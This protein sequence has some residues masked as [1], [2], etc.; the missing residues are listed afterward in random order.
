MNG[1][2]I[3]QFL[4]AHGIIPESIEHNG[5][6]R[7]KLTFDINSPHSEIIKS[8]NG[9]LWSKT[10]KAWHIP[11][12]KALLEEMVQLINE[13]KTADE[14]DTAYLTTI[15]P[16]S[17]LENYAGVDTIKIIPDTPGQ[18]DE[19]KNYIKVHC[20]RFKDFLQAQRY[21]ENTIRSYTEGLKIFLVKMLPLQV[22]EITD[23]DTIHFFKSYTY[24]KNLSIGWQRL[25]INAVKLFYKT[26]EHKKFNIENLVRPHK[27]KLLP[28]VLSKT[29]VENILKATKNEKH[30]VMLAL[31]YSCG[32]RR[33]EVLRL[34]PSNIDSDRKMLF[35]K[36]AKGRKDR[37]VPLPEKIIE[38]LRAYYKNYRPKKLLFEGQQEGKP[39]SERSFNLVFKKSCSLAKIKRPATLHWLR[40]SFATHHLEKGTDLR[41][42][43]EL[44]GHNS[45]RTTEIYTHVSAKKLNELRSPFEDL[46]L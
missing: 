24:E 39:Y 25:I 32:L 45:S 15:N 31:T 44:L 33:G 30:R 35:I 40:H 9:R 29:D 18:T 23:N 16:G 13:H 21:S 27:D 2:Q 43:Q 12:D 46:D 11:R 4:L 34:L 5:E 7:I 17:S 6:P 10:L 22:D 8:I 20:L 41:Y 37:M 14:I 19:Q 36:A 1:K 3:Q 42:I 28:N 38:M 26:I